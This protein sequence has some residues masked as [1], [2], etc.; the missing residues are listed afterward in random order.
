M[1]GTAKAA[2]IFARPAS[3][4]REIKYYVYIYFDPDTD[5]PFYVGK[6]SGHRSR[7]HLHQ[8][9]NRPLQMKIQ[10]LKARNTLPRIDKFYTSDEMAAFALE[11]ILIKSYGKRSDNSGTLF[12]VAD[13]GFA[14]AGFTGRSH[15][16]ESRLKMSI[17]RK[18]RKVSKETREKMRLA[19]L[20]RDVSHLHSEENR[21]KKAASC[22]TSDFRK[23]L[24][25]NA[26]KNVSDER[27]KEMT[28]K[29]RL[30]NLGKIVSP[31]T[32]TRMSEASK[33]RIITDEARKNMSIA[34][35]RRYAR[36]ND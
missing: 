18:G 26:K 1:A 14:T 33:R 22:G 8:T 17:A 3:P 9:H 27:L 34:Q 28:E 7:K 11:E 2:S 15:S 25:D 4:V 19:G 31:E 12:N 16:A 24:S 30:K 23:Q 5:E 29:A 32:R 20:K 36:P 10:A 35:R 21:A 13:G 6:G